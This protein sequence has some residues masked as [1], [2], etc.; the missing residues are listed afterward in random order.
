LR[1]G[2]VLDLAAPVAVMLVSVL[3]MVGDRDEP[4]AVVVNRRVNRRVA[5]SPASPLMADY[6]VSGPPGPGRGRAGR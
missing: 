6:G 2:A 4:H 5:P 1:A 3:H